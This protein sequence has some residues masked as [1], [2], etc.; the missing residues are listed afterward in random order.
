VEEEGV[1][2]GAEGSQANV[3]AL[4]PEMEKAS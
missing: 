4:T 3:E 2:E 1:S